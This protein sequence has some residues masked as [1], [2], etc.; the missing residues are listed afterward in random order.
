[1]IDKKLKN[2][3]VSDSFMLCFPINDPRVDLNQEVSVSNDHH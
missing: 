2:D 3:L 1:M